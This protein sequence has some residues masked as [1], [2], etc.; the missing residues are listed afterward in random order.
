MTAPEFFEAAQTSVAR[1]LVSEK[2]IDEAVRRVLRLRFELGLFEDP[3]APDL[4]RQK[5]VI[6]SAEHRELNLDTTRRSLVLL[7]NDGTLLLE[8]G[9][10]ADGPGGRA[11][12][13]GPPRTIAVT[14]PNADSPQDM[15][16][17]WAGDAVAARGRTPLRGHEPSGRLPV[18]F[19]RHVGQ[20]PVFHNQVRGQHGDRYADLGQDPLFAFGDGLSYITVTYSP[21]CFPRL[22]NGAAGLRAR[23]DFC[24]L[25][26]G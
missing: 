19:S 4:E 6:G 1:G 18:S 9:L 10:T 16:G 21:L 14:G 26:M 11:I 24:P 5:A 17:D 7:R 2:Q 3:R 20:A 8:G 13:Q 25:S 22:R 15:L 12:S 23:H